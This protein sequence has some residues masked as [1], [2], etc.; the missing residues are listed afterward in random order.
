MRDFDWKW[1]VMDYFPYGLAVKILNTVDQWEANREGKRKQQERMKKDSLRAEGKLKK[2]R[3]SW[4]MKHGGSQIVEAVDEEEAKKMV[5]GTFAYCD[6]LY[7]NSPFPRASWGCKEVTDVNKIETE[8]KN[9][10]GTK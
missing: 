4:V 8:N 2:F 3:V 1:F 5:D 9:S 7:N 6:D 10:E